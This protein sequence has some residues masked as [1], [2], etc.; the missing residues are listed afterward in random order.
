MELIDKILSSSEVKPI[1]II[2][3]DEG[4][5]PEGYSD[6]G[7]NNSDQ[8][9]KQKFGILNAYLLPDIDESVLY[10]S[11]SPVNSFRIVFN[12]YFRTDFEIL[13]DKHFMSSYYYVYKFL[14]VTDRL[15]GK[16][17]KSKK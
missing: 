11:I 7:A 16:Q 8:Q 13:T 2:Q 10:P 5:A 4:P 6:L 1:I 17:S 9:L 15:Y 12:L 3:S 14:D